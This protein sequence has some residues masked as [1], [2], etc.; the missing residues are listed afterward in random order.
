MQ[1]LL[2]YR[3]YR[4]AAQKLQEIE[5]LA[6]GMYT[7]KKV[8]PT[9]NLVTHNTSTNEWLDMNVS[10]LIVAYSKLLQRIEAAKGKG[11][12]LDFTIE[13]YSV[14]K[15]INYLEGLLTMAD[16]FNFEEIFESPYTANKGELI[17][18]F[19]ALLELARQCKIIIRQKQNFQEIRVFKSNIA[20]S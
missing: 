19:L 10:D 12:T 14:E 11:L 20:V 3:K 1:Q 9:G 6:I 7:R 8:E 18:T 2:E 17:V 16:H 13:Q 4:Q 15:Q 5:K